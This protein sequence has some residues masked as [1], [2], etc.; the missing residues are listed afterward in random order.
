MWVQVVDLVSRVRDLLTRR[1]TE[2]D[3]DAEIEMHLDLLTSKNIRRGM[4][5]RE[6]RRV[7]RVEFGGVT[8]VQQ[9]LREQAGFPWLESTVQDIGSAFRYFR[10]NR[11]FVAVAVVILALGIGA[12]TAVFSVSETLLLRPLSYPA[13]DRL[14]ALR[15]V[16]T[17]SDYPSTRAAPGVLADW[18]LNATSFEAIAGYRWATVDVIDGAQSDRLNGLLVTPE[19]FDVFGVP[20]LGRPFLAED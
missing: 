20:V 2:R 12:T 15:S 7:A 13:S 19:F 3:L 8:Q 4:T 9:T 5:T 16:G 11:G 14:V 1:K 6:A 10:R 18:Q 17:M